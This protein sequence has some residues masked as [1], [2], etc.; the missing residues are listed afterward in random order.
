MIIKYGYTCKSSQ[1]LSYLYHTSGRV[2]H[3]DLAEKNV[4]EKA[5]EKNDNFFEDFNFCFFTP[6][7]AKSNR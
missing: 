2:Y 4:G 7:I 6:T 3:R 5:A 1:I